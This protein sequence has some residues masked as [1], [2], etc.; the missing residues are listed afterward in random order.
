IVLKKAIKA[1]PDYWEAFNK[2]AAAKIKLKDY[3]E[4][5]KDLDKAD[6]IAPFNYETLKLKGIN[7]YLMNNFKEA[8]A[9]LDTAVYVSTEEKIDDA[10]LYYYRAQLMFKGKSY[11]TA[12]E[13]AEIA[14]EFK[15]NYTEVFLLKCE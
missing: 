5:A 3:K 12:L 9:A 11:K 15:P 2:M 10:E 7:F 4:A 8:K 13:T 14:L 1:K 6:K